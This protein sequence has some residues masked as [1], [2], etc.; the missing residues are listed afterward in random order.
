MFY[1]PHIPTE[2]RGKLL[3]TQSNNKFFPMFLPRLVYCL[4]KRRMK[5]KKLPPTIFA[6]CVAWLIYHIH[7]VRTV[8][9][10]DMPDGK[11]LVAQF[12]QA[13][14]REVGRGSPRFTGN[15]ELPLYGNRLLSELFWFFE[16]NSVRA[17]APDVTGW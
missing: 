17:T 14:G 12:P 5:S 6:I 4:A 15:F 9:K 8:R 11:V 3:P 1:C 7:F 16:V 13:C 2:H 10:W